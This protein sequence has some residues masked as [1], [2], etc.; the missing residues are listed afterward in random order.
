MPMDREKHEQLLE[1]LLTPDIEHS[2]KTEILQ[3]LRA[4]YVKVLED[5]A[6]N[7]K[8]LE[9]L[10]KDNADLVLSNSKLFRQAGILN[11]EDGEKVEEK[12][13]SETVT[14]SDLERNANL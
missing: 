8:E 14:L 9:R 5:D 7:K 10:Q 2:R 6:N 3:A 11:E 4:D 1:E 13:F 12:E